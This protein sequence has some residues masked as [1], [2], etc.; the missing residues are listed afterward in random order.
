MEKRQI[1]IAVI[2]FMVLLFCMYLYFFFQK[3]IVFHGEFLKQDSD[4]SALHYS[5][6]LGDETLNISINKDIQANKKVEVT[7]EIGSY[8]EKYNVLYNNPDIEIYKDNELIFDGEYIK[9]DS[10]VVLFEKDKTPYTDDIIADDIDDIMKTYTNDSVQVDNL[11]LPT[12]VAETAIGDNVVN[13]GNLLMFFVAMIFLLILSLDIIYPL[14]FFNLN[15]FLYVRNPEPSEFF[16]IVQ[17]AIWIFMPFV[18]IIILC[19]SLLQ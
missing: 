14:M 9:S 1:K 17:K 6:K 7:Y 18:I 8:L 4:V 10:Y 5:G 16:L 11:V 3:G 12:H 2:C 13:R 19:L 15:N